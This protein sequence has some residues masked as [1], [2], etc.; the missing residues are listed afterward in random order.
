MISQVHNR[1]SNPMTNLCLASLDNVKHRSTNLK[2]Q[3]GRSSTKQDRFHAWGACWTRL[4]PWPVSCSRYK[5][6][7]AKRSLSAKYLTSVRRYSFRVVKI[8]Y[9]SLNMSLLISL[10]SVSVWR[11]YWYC[12]SWLCVSRAPPHPIEIAKFVDCVTLALGSKYFF[13]YEIIWSIGS[14]LYRRNELLSPMEYRQCR[15][16]SCT[17]NELFKSPKAGHHLIDASVCILF[18]NGFP[19]TLLIPDSSLDL[20]AVDESRIDGVPTSYRGLFPAMTSAVANSIRGSSNIT[21][22]SCSLSVL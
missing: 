8:S 7:W 18:R 16:I 19:C 11:T 21:N 22:K 20:F 17:T 6:L 12:R 2:P 4:N 5:F 1:R 3:S 15:I 13:R 10:H 9:Q 14:R